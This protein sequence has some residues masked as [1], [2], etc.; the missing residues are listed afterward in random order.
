MQGLGLLLG[1]RHTE[2]IRKHIWKKPVPLGQE[3]NSPESFRLAIRGVSEMGYETN[4]DG[5]LFNTEAGT[6]KSINME[7]TTAVPYL[8]ADKD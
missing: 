5:Y 7:I 3:P 2:H 1:T 4:H 6:R 8:G